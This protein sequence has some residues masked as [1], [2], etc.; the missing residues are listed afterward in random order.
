[1]TLV[2]VTGLMG[3]GE[4]SASRIA[5]RA[6]W[7]VYTNTPQLH[8]CV[9]NQILV[10]HEHGI[11]MRPDPL[12]SCEG[13]LRQT[14]RCPFITECHHPA[15]PICAKHNCVGQINRSNLYYTLLVDLHANQDVVVVSSH[16]YTWSPSK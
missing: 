16:V 9:D 3:L 14:R 15:V 11:G 12:S 10:V 6:W 2:G 13:R 7:T 5:R 1:M 8:T 4:K